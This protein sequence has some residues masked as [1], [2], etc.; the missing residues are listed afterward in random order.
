MKFRHL[1]D[2]LNNEDANSRREKWIA[3]IL[4]IAVL[5]MF[6]IV[7]LL[8]DNGP[9]VIKKILTEQGYSV[10]ELE[11]E[12]IS[13]DKLGY[14]ERMY[15]SSVSIEYESGVFVDKWILSD[16][17][18]SNYFPNWV[19]SPYPPLLSEPVSMNVKIT[20]NRGQLQAIQEKSNGESVAQYINELLQ[21][22]IKG[23]QV[24]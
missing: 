1:T 6:V 16:L 13:K 5:I 18:I 11:F 17:S 22:D 8:P 21:K 7:L 4:I 14:R 10:E 19:L 24:K 23:E 12:K 9:A 3:V 20:I 2:S 15:Q